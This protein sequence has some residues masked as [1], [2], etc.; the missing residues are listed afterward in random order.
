MANV[1]NLPNVDS[2][3]IYRD[4]IYNKK[5]CLLV[6]GLEYSLYTLV[7]HIADPNAT[8]TK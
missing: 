1:L 3:P 4:A 8:K 6:L 5:L 7:L 2:L